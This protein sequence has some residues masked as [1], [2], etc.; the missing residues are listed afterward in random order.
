MQGFYPIPFYSNYLVSC[1]GVVYSHLSMAF[2]E[3]SFNSAGYHHYRVKGDDGATKTMG[4]H[5]LVAMTYIGLPENYENLDVNHLNGIKWDNRVD[6]LEWGTRQ[7]NVHHAG[8]TGLSVKSIPIQVRNTHNGMITEYP[9]YTAC[10][11]D[12]GVSEDAISWRVNAGEHYVDELFNQYR[13]LTTRQEWITPTKWS[14]NPVLVRD[15]NSGMV[16][17]YP[18]QLAVA[19]AYGVSQAYV[20]K[21]CSDPNQPLIRLGNDLHQIKHMN[22]LGDWLIRENPYLDYENNGQCRFV[23]MY[24]PITEFPRIF[25]SLTE[26]A[27]AYGMKKNIPHYRANANKLIPW[28]DGLI[29]HYL[30]NR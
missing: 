5:R 7:E 18:T 12:L 26:A 25:F 4:A 13:K 28:H 19:E 21:A 22:P 2:L 6:N 27:E 15:A 14:V 11:W 9:T 16:T 24:N 30:I 10:A 3:G 1:T 29:C 17:H 8:Y 23:V 20:S